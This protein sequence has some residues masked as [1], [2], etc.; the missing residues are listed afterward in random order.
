MQEDMLWEHMTV[1]EHLEFTARLRNRWN[2]KDQYLT[3]SFEKLVLDAR[4]NEHLNK[5]ITELSGGW[6]RMLSCAAAFIGESELIIL[7]EPTSGVDPANRRL[8]WDFIRRKRNEGKI[9][10]L[11]TH[12]MDEAEHL[13]D[14]IAIV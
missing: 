8:C 14:R 7:D 9:I 11:T 5:K 12:Y 4:L 10:V 1:G 2:K 3:Q 6:R 13:A